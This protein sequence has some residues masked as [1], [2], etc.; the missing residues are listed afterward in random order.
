MTTADERLILDVIDQAQ[1]VLAGYVEPGP[2]NPEVTIEQLILALAR[3]ELVAT[4]QRSRPATDWR[5]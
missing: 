3:P 1:R 4:V 2:R 5:W